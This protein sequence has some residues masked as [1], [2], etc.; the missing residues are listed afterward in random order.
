MHFWTHLIFFRPHPS[1]TQQ[2][3]KKR[4]RKW[5]APLTKET[6][7]R[8]KTSSCWLFATRLPDKSFSTKFW[9]VKM[10]HSLLVVKPRS[11]SVVCSFWKQRERSA[12]PRMNTLDGLWSN[13][14]NFCPSKWPI[15]PLKLKFSMSQCAL[16]QKRDIG[17]SQNVR[18]TLL[19]CFFKKRT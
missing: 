7:D 8:K 5:T 19:K 11:L 18:I 16:K 9:S 10:D 17:L 14:S 4:K 3:V 6:S 13:C 12:Q 1:L 15:S 2:C